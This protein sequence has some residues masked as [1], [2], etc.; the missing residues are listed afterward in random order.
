MFRIGDFS[1]FS[2]VSVKMLRHYDELGL[3]KPAHV[4]PFTGYRY[5][6]ADQLPRLNRIIALKDLGFSL[7]QIGAL[8]DDDLTPDQIRGLLKLR[9]AEI[10]TRLEDERSRLA[11]VETRLRQMERGDIPRHEV[12]LRQVGPLHVAMIRAAVP[13][14]GGIPPLFEA[15]EAYV[16][17]FDARAV[18]PPLTIFHDAEYRDD[19]ADVA[20]CIPIQAEVPQDERVQVVDLPGCMAACAVHTGDYDA[21]DGVLNLLLRWI[22][23]HGWTTAGP[24]REVYLRFG[25]DNAGYT[26]PDAYLAESPGGFVTEIQVPVEKVQP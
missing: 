13:A 11:R 10:Q 8:L 3:L 9:Q 18:S 2:R 4:D 16:A 22:D 26:L 21:L 1:R 12:V 24:F 6:T 20:V 23:A 5:Y 15:L 25:A 7:D 17:R 14:Q 19:V